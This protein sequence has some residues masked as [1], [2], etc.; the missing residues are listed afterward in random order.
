MK[1]RFSRLAIATAWL[2]WATASHAQDVR[3]QAPCSPVVDQTQGNVTLTFSG[4]CTVGITPAELAVIIDSVLARRAIPP[5]LLDRYEMVS[6]ALGVTDTALTTFFRILGENKVAMEDLDAKLRE[7]A[8]RHLTLLRQTEASSEDDPQIAA[9]KKQAVAAIGLGDYDRA[10][11]L[12]QRAFDA[13]LAAARRAQDAANK[14][15]LTAAKTR[16]DIAE[17]KLTQLQYAAAVEDF[18]GAA[19]LVPSAE[20]LVRSGYLNRLGTAARRAGNFPLAVTALA[21]ALS[22]RERMLDPEHQDVAVSL[23]NLA[24]LMKDTNRLSEAGPLYRRALAI[25]EK[26]Y[27]PDHPAVAIDLNNL[28]SLLQSTNR[29]GEAEPLYR[30]ALAI[31]ERNGPDHPD[32]ATDLNNLALLLQDTN[33]PSEAEPLY[34]RALAIGEKSYGPNHPDVAVG[35]N[36][37]ATLLQDTNRLGDAEPLLRRALA[38]NEKGYGPDHPDVAIRLNNLGSLLRVTNRLSEAE[39]LLRRALTINEKS[40]GRDHPVVAIGLNNLASLLQD[41][42]RLSEVEPLFRR[43]LAIGEKSYGP[44]HPAVAIRLNNLALLLHDTDRLSEAEPLL[45]R[46]LAIDEKSYGPDHPNT[47]KIAKICGFCRGNWSVPTKPHLFSQFAA[48]HRICTNTR[49]DVRF[50]RRRS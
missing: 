19:D 10:E 22:I 14:R 34:R 39:P 38:I 49:G 29:L 7:I 45:R 41:A 47:K 23:N 1:R 28:A 40:Y 27:G 21:E 43:A 42:N 48:L 2:F 18:R 4:G 15:F 26:S 36:N 20:A 25:D 6:R 50:A 30:R 3:T 17:L 12:L 8:A 35:L 33:R 13:D 46:A 44:D 31:D 5:D 9:I 11:G 16:A 32:V 37:L 24:L